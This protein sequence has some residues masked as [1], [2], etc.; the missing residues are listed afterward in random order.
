MNGDL[1]QKMGK[2]LLAEPSGKILKIELQFATKK[3]VK[4]GNVRKD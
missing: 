4:S 3:G 1:G 2:K